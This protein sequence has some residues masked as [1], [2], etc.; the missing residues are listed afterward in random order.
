MVNIR[1]RL[2]KID[3]LSEY[4]NVKK[5]TIY[6]MVYRKRIPYIKI[7]NLLRFD[8][9]TI[10]IWLSSKTYIPF[11]LEKCYNSL[12]VKGDGG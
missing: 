7:N 4:I 9:E 10:N 3:E 12:Q 1:K 11:E 2:L 6:D 5:S 8:K